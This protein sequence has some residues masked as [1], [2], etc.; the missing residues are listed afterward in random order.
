MADVVAETRLRAAAKVRELASLEEK[1]RI[2]AMQIE[3]LKKQQEE[4]EKMAAERA[5]LQEQAAQNQNFFI[6]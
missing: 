1:R 3:F 4:T 5:R 2:D 6:Q